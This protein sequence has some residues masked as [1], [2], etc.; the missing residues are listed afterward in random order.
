MVP[1]V[2]ARSRKQPPFEASSVNEGN[3]S[4]AAGLLGICSGTAAR[5]QVT[6]S[7]A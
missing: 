7:Y 2:T 6:M 3:Q 1:D 4:E 5:G